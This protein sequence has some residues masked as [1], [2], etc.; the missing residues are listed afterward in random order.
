MVLLTTQLM[1]TVDSIY[2]LD[3][4]S[5]SVERIYRIQGRIQGKQNAVHLWTRSVLV[6]GMSLNF[7]DRTAVCHLQ[8]DNDT[9]AL[10][11]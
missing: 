5:I 1:F 6:V 11:W 2:V 7:I 8:T 9:V 10:G 3:I 4:V